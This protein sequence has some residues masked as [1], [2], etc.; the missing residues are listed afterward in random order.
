MANNDLIKNIKKQKW[1]KRW[2]GSYTF[3]SCSYWAPQY[4]KILNKFLGI[5]FKTSLFIHREGIVTFLLNIDELD[6]FGKTL[7]KKAEQNPEFAIDILKKLKD[8]T[9]QIMMIMQELEGKIPTQKQYQNFLIYFEKHLAYHNFMK[10][11]VDYMDVNV[12]DNLIN[13]F[14]DARFYSEPVYSRSEIFFREL[15]KAIAKKEKLDA[16]LLTCLTQQELETY[17]KTT[18]LPEQSILKDRFKASVLLFD[19]GKLNIITGND[20]NKIEYAIHEV[21]QH[22]GDNQQNILKGTIAFPGK[23]KGIARIVPDPFNPGKFNEGDILITGMT[24]PEFLPLMKKASA[25]VTDVGGMLCHAALVSREL[26]KP[27]IVGTKIATQMFKDGELIDVDANKGVVKKVKN[28]T[29]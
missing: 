12:L 21:I 17:F 4:D 27:C 23:V 18:K 7:A 26:R 5:G 22:L 10:K 11:T 8:N 1:I 15:A 2:A 3:T 28:R 6:T 19:D 20:V 16:E 14:K 25:I 9:T 29:E 24:R 13:Y